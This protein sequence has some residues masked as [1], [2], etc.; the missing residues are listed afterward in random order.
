TTAATAQLCA[1]TGLSPEDITG[2]GTGL[3]AAGVTHKIQVI[4]RALSR[5]AAVLEDAASV[6]RVLGGFEISALTGAYI[7]AAQAGMAVLV[8]GFIC[9]AAALC[10]LRLNPTIRPYLFF[11]H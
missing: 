3:N 7:A 10:A 11:S 8:D 4:K 5:H 1:L 2:A 9:A 6:S